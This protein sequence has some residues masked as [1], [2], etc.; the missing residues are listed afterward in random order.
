MSKAPLGVI[1]SGHGLEYMDNTLGVAPA[2]GLP[3]ARLLFAVR[4]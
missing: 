3:S 1:I 4:S 2:A